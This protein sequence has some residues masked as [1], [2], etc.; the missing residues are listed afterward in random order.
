MAAGDQDRTGTRD[1]AS[2]QEPAG[3]PSTGPAHSD[4]GE[5]G[6]AAHEEPLLGRSQREDF[7]HRWET[8]QTS[9]VD[10]PRR[11]VDQA[12]ELVTDTMQTIADNFSR[13]RAQ[14]EDQWARGDDVSTE[15][16]RV[17]LQQYRTFFDRLLHI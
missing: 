4:P 3:D 17:S 9:F 15:D 13:Q 7:R 8:I 10:E 11:A 6:P 2:P 12:D 16:L 1:I 5:T 14:L